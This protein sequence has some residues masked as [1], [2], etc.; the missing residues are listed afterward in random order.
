MK[1]HLVVATGN[2]NKMRE[3]REILKDL[4]VE[5]LSME[6]AGV[7]ADIVEDGSSFEE[8]AVI[9]AKTVALSCGEMAIADDS[10]LVI[11]ALD[12]APGI[13]SARFMGHDTPYEKK[14]EEL[15]NP[16]L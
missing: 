6:E 8:N 9:K 10:G 13:H 1:K 2:K 16:F 11:D 12:G 5:I 3:I 15:M 7:C 14:N 4:D